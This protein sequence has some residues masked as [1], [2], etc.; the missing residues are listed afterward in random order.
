MAITDKQIEDII[1]SERPNRLVE[2]AQGSELAAACHAIH[3]MVILAMRGNSEAIITLGL[4][5]SDF[6]NFDKSS[7]L[8]FYMICIAS[9]I[10]SDPEKIRLLAPLVPWF[11]DAAILSDFGAKFDTWIAT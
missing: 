10:Q 1:S 8:D 6:I 2:V 3:A 5:K 9:A 4:C 11:T 7:H